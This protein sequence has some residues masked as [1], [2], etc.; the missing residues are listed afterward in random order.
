MVSWIFLSLEEKSE[1]A[2]VV[3]GFFVGS[4]PFVPLVMTCGSRTLISVGAAPFSLL[5]TSVLMK[6]RS[7]ETHFPGQAV[8]AMSPCPRMVGSFLCVM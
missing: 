2:E 8:A 6:G 4:F 7:S 1:F 5:F 3:A